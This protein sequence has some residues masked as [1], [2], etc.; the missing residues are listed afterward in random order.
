M[1]KIHSEFWLR[2]KSRADD[3]EV[4]PPVTKKGRYCVFWRVGL[5]P[6]RISD[7]FSA[8]EF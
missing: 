5:C 7:F 8:I 4:V 3:T 1:G 2:R 6:D